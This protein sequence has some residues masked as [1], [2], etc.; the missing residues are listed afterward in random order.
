MI[1][2]DALGICADLDAAMDAHVAN[3]EDEWAA[4]LADPAKLRRF[5]SFVNAPSTPDPSLGY[6]PER[7]QVRPAS[8]EERRSG[9]VLIAS[10]TLEVRR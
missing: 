4:T 6:V 10:T 8:G 2:D 7:G 3:Y 9:A 5:Q 1:F